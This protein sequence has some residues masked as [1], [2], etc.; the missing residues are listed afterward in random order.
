[1]PL[2][3]GKDQSVISKNISELM[4]SFKRNGKIGTSKPEDKSAA[5]KQAIAISYAKARDNG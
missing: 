1:M 2:F 4:N 5:Q 3:K